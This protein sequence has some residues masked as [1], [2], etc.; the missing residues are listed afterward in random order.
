MRELG[1]KKLLPSVVLSGLGGILVWTANPP[2]DPTDRWMA[3]F[4]AFLL[5]AS[6]VYFVVAWRRNR[7]LS[8]RPEEEAVRAMLPRMLYEVLLGVAAMDGEPVERHRRAVADV[9]TRWWP[10]AIAPQDL[11]RWA[12]TVAPAQ[13]PVALVQRLAVVLTE[14]ERAALLESGRAVAP[15]AAGNGDDVLRRIRGVLQPT[16]RAAG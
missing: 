15:P 8:G 3:C 6:L 16:D 2:D 5:V 9:L 14:H 12:N 11:E 10:G 4:G 7:A 1:Q 13:D